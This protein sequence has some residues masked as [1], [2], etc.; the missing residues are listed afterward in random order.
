MHKSQMFS[1]LQLW[2]QILA[3]VPPIQ[4]CG[5][6]SDPGVDRSDGH[7]VYN[8]DQFNK[9]D[10]AADGPAVMAGP[11]AAVLAFMRSL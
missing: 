5:A 10:E 1:L 9:T 11:P 8:T 7:C 3:L 6:G 2:L 4:S